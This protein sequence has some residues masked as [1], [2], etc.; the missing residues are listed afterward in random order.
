MAHDYKLRVE[1][2]G[3]CPTEYGYGVY[4][5][6]IHND[7]VIAWEKVPF[8]SDDETHDAAKRRVRSRARYA[9]KKDGYRY[10]NGTWS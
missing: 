10:V 9:L 8:D 7:C 4:M 1:A 3:D 2:S 5:N 6:A